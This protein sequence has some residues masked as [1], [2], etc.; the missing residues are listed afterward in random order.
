MKPK[1]SVCIVANKLNDLLEEVLHSFAHTDFELCLGFNGNK[2]ENLASIQQQFPFLKIVQL[3]W[4]GYGPTKN[5]LAENAS[6]D[7]ILSID[8]DEIANLE[9]TTSLK[10]ISLEN[11]NVVYSLK[12]QQRIGKHEINNGSYGTPEWKI[13]LYNKQFSSWNNEI[14]HE[15]LN[16]PKTCIQHKLEGILWHLTAS[17]LAE[18]RE[19]NNHYAQLSAEN[20]LAKGKTVSAIKPLLSG[21]MAFIKQYF[22][23]KGILDGKIGFQLASE[24]ARYTSLKYSI[25]RKLKK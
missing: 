6:C 9:L 10:Q 24:I 20:M 2:D 19:K 12:R 15:E 1:L 11:D 18:I 21:T 3:E 25:A 8:S 22:I 16:L 23:K 13:R 4:I 17:N 7:W 14:V 5:K